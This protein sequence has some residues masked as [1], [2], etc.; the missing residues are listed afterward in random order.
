MKR[1]I[2]IVLILLMATAFSLHAQT[3]S[4]GDVVTNG[5]GSKG[6]VFYV[7]E[8][9]TDGWMVAL[10]DLPTHHWGLSSD[11]PSLQN[12]NTPLSL[13]NETSG[14]D[15]TDIIRQFHA[16]QGYT[17]TYGAGLVDFE[18]EWYIPTAGQ[19]QKLLSALNSINDIFAQE[20]GSTLQWQPYASSTEA[21]TSGQIWAVDFGDHGRDWGGLFVNKSKSDDLCFRAVRNIRNHPILPETTL[22]DN[23]L[24]T[25]CNRPL[26]GSPWNI[27]LLSSSSFEDVASYSPVLVGDIDGN[28]VNDIVTAKYNNNNYRSCE[29]NVYSGIDLSLQHCFSVPDTIYLSNGPYAIGRYPN[30]DGTL[31]GA[32]FTH[33]FDK[34][35]RAYAIDGTLLNVS[36]R[37]TSCDGMV[38]L[39]DF[40]GDGYLEVYS[41]SDIFDAAT[42]KWLCSGPDNGNKGLSYRGSRA[43]VNG[44]YHHTYYA[45]SLASDVLDDEMQELI[46]GNTIYNVNINSRTNPN[47]NSVTVSKTIAPPSG[48]SADGHVSL[49]DFD[50]DG[51]CEV[52]VIRDNTNDYTLDDTYFY[53]YRPSS[54]QIIFQK[55]HLC[56][57]TSYV[58]IGNIDENPHPEIVFLENQPNGSYEEI[59]C[60]RYTTQNGLNTIWTKEHDDSSGMT[61]M[62]LFDFNQDNIM[63]L[64]Y[65]DNKNLRIINASGKSHITG[66]DTIRPYNLYT[67]Q[68]AAGTGIEYPVVADVNG[69]GAAEIIVTGMLDQYFGYDVGYGGIY[70]FGSPGNWG[71]AR[72]VWNQYMYH[73]TNVNEDL[74]IPTYCFNTA[75]VF[76]GPD[77]SI[78]RPFNNFLQQAT[79]ITQYGEPIG[80]MGEPQYV[81]IYDHLYGVYTWN[82]TTYTAPGEYTQQF[83]DIHGCDSIVTLHLSDEPIETPD[84]ILESDCNAPLEGFEWGI[85]ED[86]SSGDN[87]YCRINPL[88]GDLDDDG[89]PEIVCFDMMGYNPS[90]TAA[91]TINVYDGRDKYLKAQI[92]V[93]GLVWAHGNGPYG[94]VKLPS[95]EGLIVTACKDS[96]LYAYNISLANS[97]IP[98]WVSNA[99]YN[100]GYNDFSV[101]IGFADFNGDGHP[102]VYVRDKIFNAETGVLLATAQGGTNEADSYS[103]NS[104]T[105][106]NKLSCPLAFDICGDTRQ[107]LIL[108]N[109]IYDVVITNPNGTTGNHVTLTKSITPPN[110][111]IND[112]H[113]QVADFNLDGHPD[114]LI[115]NRDAEGSSGT[116]SFYVWD[117]FNNQT[118]LPIQLETHFTGKSVPLIADFENDGLLELLIDCC[119]ENDKGLRAYRFNPTTNGFSFLWSLPIDED[120]YSNSATLFDF[121]ADGKNELVYT[122]N[123]FMRIY[124][125]S[126]MPPTELSMIDCGEIS[127]MQVPIVADVDD[128]G[129]AEIVVTGKAGGYMQADTELKVFKSSTEPWRPARKVW[130]QYMYHVTNVNEDLTI[131]NYCYN[132]ATTFTAPDG[133]IRRP[134][135]NFLQQASYFTQYGEPI[136]GMGEPQ[137]V[138]IYDHLDG[139]YTW[140]ET[141]YTTPGEYTQQFTDIHGCDS[142][143]TLHL[144]DEPIETPDNILESDCNDNTP[145]PFEGGVLLHQTPD[146]VHVYTTPLC[147]DIDGDGIIDI[148]VPHY[149]ATDDNYKHW[150]NQLGIYSG[151]DLALQSTIS[152]P[153]EIYLQYCPIGLAKY[154]MDNGTLQGAIFVMCNDG[155]IR[156]YSR[157][158]QLL[159]TSDYDP[160]CEGPLSFADFNNDGYAEVY[161]GNTVYDA[162]TLK[163][164]CSGPDAGNKGLS[165]RGSPNSPYPHR[166]LYA[167]SYAYNVLGDE[168]LELICGNTIYNVNITS[169][170][171]PSLNSITTNKTIT[172]P[173]GYPQDGQVALAD[174]DLDGEVE[175]VV[176]KDLTDDCTVDNAYLYAYRPSN[177]EILFQYSLLCRSIGFPAI[178]NIDS[179]P[180]PEI[181]FVDYQYDTYTEK[182]R[183]M[184]YTTGSGINTL[185]EIHHNDPS[186]MTTM[187]FFDFNLDEIPEIV[188]RDAYNLNI[189]NGSDGAIL[190]SYPMRSGTAGEHPIIAD[191]NSDGHAEVIATGLLDDYYGNNGYGSLNVF[192]NSNWPDARPVWN[193]YVYNVTN[194][195]EDLT[196]P[197]FCFN[198]ATVFTA[199]DGTIR[200][201]YNNFLEQAYY[202]TPEGEPIGT[203]GEPQ[204]VDLFAS[205]YES[206]EWNGTIYTEPGDYTQNFIDSHGCDSIVTLHL[207]A[208]P[209][210]L[211]DNILESDCNVPLQGFEWGIREDWS[212]EDNIYCRINP[213]VGDLDDD[214]IPEIVCFDM[215]GNN[216]SQTA[217]KTIN[218]YDGRDKYLKAQINVEGLVWAHGNG[219]YGLV[220]LPHREGLIVTACKDSKLYAYDI[221]LANLGIPVWVSNANYNTGYND[222]SVSIGFADFNGDGHPEVYVRDKIFNAETGILLATAQGGNN[223]ADSYSHN[224]HTNHNKLSCPLAYDICGDTR[225][226]LI[227]GNEIYDVVI[228]NPNGTTGN[229][230]TLTKSITPPNGIINDGHVQVADFNLD[231]HPDILISNR[232]AEGSSGIVSFYVWDVFNNRTSLPIQLE[233]HFTG[234]SVPLIA[235]F[236]DDGFLEL[237][238][239]CCHENDKGLRAYRFNPAT[240]GFSFLWSLP[241]DEDS[242]SNTA[243]L[244]DF[245]ADGKNELIY[246]D[247]SYMRIY[248][249]STTPPIEIS[250]INCGEISIMQVP[251]VADVDNDGSAEIVVTGKA[252]GYMQANTMLKVYKSSTEPWRPARKI[253]NQYMYHVTNVNEDLTIPT[254]CFNTATVF[255]GADGTIRRPYNNFLQ[256][257]GYYTPDGELYN[258]NGTVE[259]DI[260]GSGCRFF[261][262]NGV[263]YEESGHYEQ[264]IEIPNGCDTLFNIEVSI[265]GTVTY[266]WSQEACGEYVWNGITYTEPGVYEQSFVTPD[267]CDSIVHLHLSF[268]G[269]PEAI[270]EIIGL[271]EVNVSTD[272]ILGQYFYHIDSV[273]LAT[274]YEWELEGADWVMDTDGMQCTIIVISPDTAILKVKAWNDCGY[275]EQEITIHAGFF[276]VEE[277]QGFPFAMYPNPAHDKVFIEAEDI[278]RIRLFD[279]LGQCLTERVTE[280]C[281]RVELSLQ[282]CAT[283]LYLIEIQTLY[284][285]IRTKLKISPQ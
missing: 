122:D 157:N 215:M 138:D 175:V 163:R 261:I 285:T 152:I 27:Q 225:Q 209:I 253:W 177:G 58:F 42:L 276:D 126:T 96:K 18:N 180:H 39:A 113:V 63:E 71:S 22:P 232:D 202:I 158:G 49:A 110:G 135:N 167:I 279:M 224:S 193:Q 255:T 151:N 179:D 263:R 115:S 240:N 91:K 32:I 266:E 24:E 10:N 164:L 200:R 31:Q 190:Y 93:E 222:F 84:N 4:I 275:T 40:N 17:P 181:V 94:L 137:Y 26:D 69:D 114:I 204:H 124:D 66:N 76:T 57:S 258:P 14:Y 198:N 19:L 226:E 25:Y 277:N 234:K 252:D 236:D 160:S 216:P 107:E 229:H 118:S 6:I 211:P 41:G 149:T 207:T 206:Y 50:L 184:R 251:I 166:S 221:S 259:V 174:L 188:Y 64:V 86:W 59:I 153:E 143:V 34:K 136:G 82:G 81:D 111:I 196:V 172:P 182:M 60:W 250:M 1:P 218:V 65:R 237:L 78:R 208:T 20:G 269:Q 169:R 267:G 88:V 284:G 77:G 185:W 123:S 140:N 272:L 220:K 194:V 56:S 235:D 161:V 162:A 52:L 129:S 264:L 5:D 62:T 53:A 212:S 197:S 233:T 243:T 147:G 101:S 28:G 241:I 134:F 23:I 257:A 170:T 105:N 100:T 148:V 254:S 99:N 142:I 29:I 192:G 33:C 43:Y 165:Y 3:Y 154:P 205:F 83:T 70:T 72:P 103:H 21:N 270:P 246:T 95:R 37:P 87:I 281:E 8:D 247:N 16:S 260:T 75:T 128:D 210:D 280:P 108:G 273:P 146:N 119:H 106:H 282:G 38:S 168:K 242:Y 228:T 73:V 127:I 9:R 213:L 55:A 183:C 144:S 217:A 45:M 145:I 13:L 35:I 187:A 67:R 199:S 201:P 238:I 283:A 189:M 132:T 203:E 44:E 268:A 231:G 51:E 248:D 125:L 97:G 109:E 74:T 131:P 239:D 2:Q 150:S 219:P 46:C 173:S 15:N 178:C 90:Q 79:Y 186:G 155:K 68:M 89:I 30:A 133:F 214:G 265:G 139:E 112:G 191:I 245:N 271:T 117:V 54:G 48:Y 104:H 92:N 7:T 141:T 227:L 274:H 156:S 230:V 80:E 159:N 98:V 11:I 116:V 36:D 61:A 249:L 262:F 12:L 85:R 244:F 195:N 130:N 223:Q 121:N 278:V 120:S 176:T 171:N 102:E 256:Q 47:L